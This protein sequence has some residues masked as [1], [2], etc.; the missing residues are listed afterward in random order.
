LSDRELQ[1]DSVHHIKAIL[2]YVLDKIKYRLTERKLYEIV[3]DSGVINYFYCSDA[4]NELIANGAV[5]RHE[6]NGETILEL[7]EKGRQSSAYFRK[8]IPFYFRK[9]LLVAAVSRIGREKR[10]SETDISVNK[11]ENGYEVSC[12]IK[13]RNFVL[14]RV[15][16]YVPGEEYAR[17]FSEQMLKNPAGLYDRVL[18]AV[19][20]N[21]EED[22]VVE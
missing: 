3:L 2:C 8:N 11:L 10:E 9:K 22:I 21:A 5:S 4:L 20:G 17:L 7:E 16:V 12:A 19:L 15:S 18:E 14:M 1:L 6:E 13:D